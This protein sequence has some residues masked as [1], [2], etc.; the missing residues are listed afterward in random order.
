MGKDD[1]I[2]L[3]RKPCEVIFFAVGIF[4]TDNPIF[5]SNCHKINKKYYIR[6]LYDMRYV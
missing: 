6:A 3:I 1:N 2:K 4:Y 5:H